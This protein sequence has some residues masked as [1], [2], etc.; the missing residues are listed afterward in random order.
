MYHNCEILVNSGNQNPND[1]QVKL[2][3]NMDIHPNTE[4]AITQGKFRVG[5]GTTIDSSN[6][7]FIL[8]WGSFGL[9]DVT[10]VAA[11]KETLNFMY[12]EVI[13]FQHG[14]WDMFASVNDESGNNLQEMSND[15]NIQNNLVDSINN[16]TRYFCWAWGGRWQTTS[17]PAIWSY[18]PT[19]ESKGPNMINGNISGT[20]SPSIAITAPGPAAGYTTVKNNVGVNQAC[21]AITTTNLPYPYSFDI[22]GAVATNPQMW[23]SLNLKGDANVVRRIFGGICTETQFTYRTKENYSE[24]KDFL[25]ISRDGFGDLDISDTNDYNNNAIFGWECK[26]NTGALSYFRREV[27]DDGTAGEIAQSFVTT[28]VYTGANERTIEFRPIIALNAHIT[29]FKIH[30]FIDLHG[31]GG[32]VQA[33]DGA[34]NPVIF[35]LT[36][37]PEYSKYR[38]RGFVLNDSDNDINLTACPQ[39][40]FVKNSSTTTLGPANDGGSG[41]RLGNIVAQIYPRFIEAGQ[42]IEWSDNGGGNKGFGTLT[43][44]YSSILRKANSASILLGP[45]PA[46]NDDGFYRIQGTS[47]N[48]VG[49]PAGWVGIRV[50]ST[51]NTPIDFHIELLNLP[52]QNKSAYS[53]HGRTTFRVLSE[54]GNV[55]ENNF[56]IIEPQNLIYHK[57]HNKQVFMLDHLRV[58]VTDVDGTLFEEFVGTLTLNIHLKTNPHSMLQALTGA[59]MNRSQKDET[60]NDYEEIEKA[61][62]NVF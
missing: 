31:G 51:D 3:K 22:K 20:Q 2:P 11:D 12:P 58:R 40:Y 43:T 45:D 18:V 9:N 17:G 36:N 30:V 38:Y 53:T 21:C 49:P 13:K 46:N 39:E 44:E 15:K 56:G 60:V 14:K 50:N 7:T 29:E 55:A 61:S 42:I 5:Q 48:T 6:D 35:D 59:I 41:G 24:E 4:V 1:F 10:A 52:L 23:Y 16:Q 54:Y 37:L 57:L 27:N 33:T 34:G 26:R 19:H 32:L 28:D 47:S 62:R 25:S 8:G